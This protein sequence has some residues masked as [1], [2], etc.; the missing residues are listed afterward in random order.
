[1][2]FSVTKDTIIG[3]VLDKDPSTE[4]LFLDLGMHCLFCPSARGET[5]EEACSVHGVDPAELVEK[6][7]KHFSE[8]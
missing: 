5:I 4:P 7:N 3:D 8:N 1:M 6:L 2:A